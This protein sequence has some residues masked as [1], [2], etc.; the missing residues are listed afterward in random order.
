MVE[1][2]ERS[3]GKNRPKIQTQAFKE[4]VGKTNKSNSK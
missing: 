2:S 3:Y 4:T 1:E